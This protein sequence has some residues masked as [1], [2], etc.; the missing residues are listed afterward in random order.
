VDTVEPGF[1]AAV[2]TVLEVLAG[3]KLAVEMLEATTVVG[4]RIAIDGYY[5]INSS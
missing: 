4:R 1:R 3:G 2:V 5:R